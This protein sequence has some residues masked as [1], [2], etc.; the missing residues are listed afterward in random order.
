MIQDGSLRPGEELPTVRAVAVGLGV[1]PGVVQDAYD[2]LAG[3]GLLDP[4]ERAGPR[5][6]AYADAGHSEERL[7]A[8]TSLCQEFLSRMQVCGFTTPHVLQMLRTLTEREES[9]G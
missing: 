1:P 4:I 3:E 6:L 8:L 7:S 5:V 9:H 2:R